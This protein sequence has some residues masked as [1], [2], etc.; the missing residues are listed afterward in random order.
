VKKWEFNCPKCD[1]EYKIRLKEDKYASIVDDMA[2]TLIKNYIQEQNI[3][4]K[5]EVICVACK[6]WFKL[7]DVLLLE[8]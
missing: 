8:E 6:K 3:L 4:N 7:G 1:A 2:G 5:V